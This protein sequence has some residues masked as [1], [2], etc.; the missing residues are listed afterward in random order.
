MGGLAFLLVG[1][2]EILNYAYVTYEGFQ[3]TVVTKQIQVPVG[4]GAPVGII[5]STSFQ[6]GLFPIP[7]AP[8]QALRLVAANNGVFL[9]AYMM[10]LFVYL[11]LIPGVLG[12]YSSIRK[13]NEAASVLGLSFA[14]V[15]LLAYVSTSGTAISFIAIANGYANA[16]TDSLRTIYLAQAQALIPGGRFVGYYLVS[17]LLYA[18][19]LVSSF[20]ML[21]GP[22]NRV[23]AY[24]GIA[25]AALGLIFMVAFVPDVVSPILF[26]A[27]FF[28]VGY[29]LYRP[30]GYQSRL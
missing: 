7:S 14:L 13:V 17:G 15:G 8:D 11:A 2:L 20:V 1:V 16:S 26:V 23:I 24:L 9:A 27:W 19:V 25:A 28:V 3:F 30:R 4:L 6:I 12:L 21:R 22:F 5:N 29:R 18:A 10:A